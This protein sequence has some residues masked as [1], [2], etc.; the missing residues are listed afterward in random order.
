MALSPLSV[1][2][3]NFN[4]N[5]KF[6]WQN[7]QSFCD[8]QFK[9]S[10][11]IVINIFKVKRSYQGSQ[12]GTFHWES[13]KDTIATRFSVWIA[14]ILYHP[15]DQRSAAESWALEAVTETLQTN[16]SPLLES[17]FKPRCRT[18]ELLSSVTRSSKL[19]IYCEAWAPSSDWMGVTQNSIPITHKHCAAM[20]GDHSTVI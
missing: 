17:P 20:S 5:S 3:G 19:N 13:G 14:L 7:N 6:R 4:W 10:W 16:K 8:T 1:I 12:P 15:I 9:G 11:K 18:A 2:R